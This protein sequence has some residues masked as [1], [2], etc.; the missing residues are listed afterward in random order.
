MS[1]KV[2]LLVALAAA[3]ATLPGCQTSHQ[4]P[5]PEMVGHRVHLTGQFNGPGKIADFILLPNDAHV[6]LT[7]KPDT[8]NVRIEYG[9]PVTVDGILHHFVAPGRRG[10]DAENDAYAAG[11]PEYYF[12]EDATVRP[13]H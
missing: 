12:I 9:T 7:G 6:Y 3:L 1:F 8:A 10:P 4:G 11:I 5:L 2:N 13:A